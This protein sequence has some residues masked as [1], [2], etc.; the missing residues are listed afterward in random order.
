ML[1]EVNKTMTRLQYDSII[2]AFELGVD[3]GDSREENWDYYRTV[4]PD[5]LLNEL[6]YAYLQASVED[7]SHKDMFGL[8]PADEELN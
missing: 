8:R 4:N 1:E 2:D 7:I 5:A 3:L 6:S